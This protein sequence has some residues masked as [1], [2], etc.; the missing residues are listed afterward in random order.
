MT[1]LHFIYLLIIFLILSL[2][3]LKYILY[4]KYPYPNSIEESELVYKIAKERT[5]EDI[6]FFYKTNEN[7][8]YAFVDIL[9]DENI[10]SINYKIVE[11]NIFIILLKYLFYRQRPFKVNNKVKNLVLSESTAYT[12]SYPSGHSYQAFYIA[13][14]YSRKY[15][16]LKDKLYE[17]AEKCANARVIGGVHYPSDIKFGKYL[18]EH[19]F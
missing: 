9:P 4:V 8:A 17:T 13:K 16:E 2:I 15:P 1:L 3:I 7:V 10:T 14:Y 6:D 19:F 18:A 11:R 5:Q 12:P